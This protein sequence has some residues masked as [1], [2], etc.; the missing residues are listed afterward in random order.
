LLPTAITVSF[1]TIWVNRS[2]GPVSFFH[3]DFTMAKRIR[4]DEDV[5]NAKPGRTLSDFVGLYI[6]CNPKTDLKSWVYRYSFQGTIVEKRLG[7]WPYVNF[8]TA[9]D[10]AM[11]MKGLL[12]DRINPVDP[13]EAI[14]WNDKLKK[15][16]AQV[17][18]EWIALQKPRWSASQ[19]YNANHLLHVHGKALADV[20]MYKIDRHLVDDAIAALRAEHPIQAKR[21]IKMWEK[22][23]DYADYKGYR[24]G[25]NPAQWKGNVERGFP[26]IGAAKHH[27]SL[28]YSQI[29]AFVQKLRVLQERSTSAVAMEFLI[30]TAARTSE[31]LEAQFGEFD[32][33]GESGLGPMWVIPAHR[34]KARKVHRVPL[35]PRAVELIRRQL[36][37]RVGDC[38]FVFT[39][40]GG[41][42]PLSKKSLYRIAIGVSVTA[43]GFRSSFR[44]WAGDKGFRWDVCEMAL[45]HVVGGRVAQAYSPGDPMEERRKLMEAWAAFITH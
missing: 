14:K 40:Y 33:D 36:E 45:A 5:E 10:Q 11:G 38:P 18:D 43:H 23:F 28:H 39:G 42:T 16:F 25:P 32:L 24:A 44:S 8:R 12:L 26:S 17:A 22:V 7:R 37:H 31:V 2:F 4:T 29:P 35:S 20:P 30:L 21:A 41:Q 3:E 15:T 27:A 9:R 34:M 1:L 19:L 6:H 13:R